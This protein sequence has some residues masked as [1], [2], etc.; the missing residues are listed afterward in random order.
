MLFWYKFFALY[1]LFLIIFI[2]YFSRT[3]ILY[4]RWNACTC[5]YIV[6]GT[7]IKFF[8]LSFARWFFTSPPGRSVH[9]I[10]V[11][12]YWW[13]CRES[14]CSLVIFPLFKKQQNE[15]YITFFIFFLSQITH[16]SHRYANK[17]HLWHHRHVHMFIAL[18]YRVS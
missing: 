18:M 16:A 5:S 3:C 1:D 14:L 2:I 9:Q 17:L 13:K 11:L 10:S 8:V 12:I 4:F 6:I 7:C 15:S